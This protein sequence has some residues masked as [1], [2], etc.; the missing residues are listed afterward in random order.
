M[1][2]WRSI[3]PLVIGVALTASLSGVSTYVAAQPQ[4][5]EVVVSARRYTES[6]EDAPLAVNVMSGAYLEDQQVLSMQDL[7]ELTP[8]VTWGQFTKA[9]SS[10]QLRGINSGNPGNASQESGMSIVMD[11]IPLTRPFLTSPTPFDLERVEVMRGPQGTTFGRNSTTGVVHFISGRPSQEFESAI[12]VQTGTLNLAHVSGF[13]SGGLSDTVSARIAFNAKENDVGL[14]DADTGEALESESNRAIRGSLLIQP[15]DDFSAYLKAE[16]SIDDDLPPSRWAAACGPSNPWLSDTDIRQG[17]N[18]APAYIAG[19]GGYYVPCDGWKSKQSPPPVGGYYTKRTITT[20]TSELAWSLDNDVT[21]TWLSG[22][23]EGEHRNTQDNRGTPAVIEDEHVE[24]VGTVASTELR[25]DNSASGNPFTWLAGVYLLRDKEDR[26]ESTRHCAERDG[27]FGCDT[28]VPQEPFALDRD[29]S[30]RTSS[31]AVFGELSFDITDRLNIAVGGRYTNDS[32]DYSI[33]ADGWGNVDQLS[34]FGFGGPR[35][36]DDPAN[37]SVG[38]YGGTVC[39]TEA[40]PMGFDRV[41]ISDSWDAFTGKLSVSYALTDTSNL[42]F[43][44]SQGF[45]SGGFQNDVIYADF[46]Y[47]T[48]FDNED[49]DNYELGWKAAY[50][51]GRIAVTLFDI[52]QTNA[53]NSILFSPSPTSNFQLNVV[54]NLGGIEAQGIE[55]E[56]AILIG[57]NFTLGG[58]LASQKSEYGPGTRRRA[59]LDPVTGELV[60]GQDISGLDADAPELTYVLY[61]EYEWGLANGSRIRLRAD[62]QH[63]DFVWGTNNPSAREELLPGG[64][65]LNAI[66]PEIDNVG[67]SVRWTSPSGDINVT[68]WGKNLGDDLDWKSGTGFTPGGVYYLDTSTGTFNNAR[69]VSGREQVGLDV[70]FRF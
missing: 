65:D 36:C 32:R 35:S 24:N 20:L 56:G 62:I 13:V 15:N 18:F 10:F 48:T 41:S 50:D 63:R 64:S 60:G 5:E 12:N 4:L 30:G 67:A 68:L 69:G 26:L 43:L 2:S 44:F 9:Q 70:G 29:A 17:R 1:R 46:L 47:N 31:Y 34:F 16:V 19:I 54:S 33:E 40:N 39:G 22:Y 38:Q 58:N 21:L 37:Q 11:G 14:E 27:H 8:G 49:V 28:V 25:L 66:R 61:G 55:I 57:D 23:I 45:K 51:R 3:R 52:E 59:A 42:Y 7:F 6:L 53:Q